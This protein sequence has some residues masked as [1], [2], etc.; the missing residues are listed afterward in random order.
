MELRRR[1][2][3]GRHEINCLQAQRI[4]DLLAT[5]L[6]T[7]GTPLLLAGDELGRIQAGNNHA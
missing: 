2:A 4:R 5:Q 1:G 7:Q 6:L 3:P